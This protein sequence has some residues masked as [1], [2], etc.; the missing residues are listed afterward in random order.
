MH[1]T[2][3]GV[4]QRCVTQKKTHINEMSANWMK[5]CLMATF[6]RYF[7]WP[8]AAA[9]HDTA[10]DVYQRQSTTQNSCLNDTI[11]SRWSKLIFNNQKITYEQ[12]VWQRVFRTNFYY[13]QH[14]IRKQEQDI[15]LIP[16]LETDS[17]YHTRENTKNVPRIT[18][19]TDRKA[20]H[21]TKHTL[22][23]TY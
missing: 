2:V 16:M 13:K 3:S 17:K 14:A 18:W 19:I 12:Y 20:H 4:F 10:H 15:A 22:I 1:A 8:D 9:A 6:R 21:T 23:F 7:G 11:P 5:M